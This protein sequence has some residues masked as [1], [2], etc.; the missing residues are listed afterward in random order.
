MIEN[1]NDSFSNPA[2]RGPLTGHAAGAGGRN[3]RL[4]RKVHLEMQSGSQG[5]SN[6]RQAMLFVAGGL[7]AGIAV[8]SWLGR[9]ALPGLDSGVDRSEI[10]A[11]TSMS[12]DRAIIE[13]LAA[14]ERRVADETERRV[15]LESTL[16]TL[17]ERL[18]PDGV[19]P[20]ADDAAAPL[21]LNEIDRPNRAQSFAALRAQMRQQAS[22]DY[23]REQLIAAGF[24]PDQAQSLIDRESQMR[25]EIMN[26]SYEARRQGEA[27]NPRDVQ[28]AMQTE[29][30]TGLGDDG[31]ARYLE[32]TGQPTSVGVAEV[33]ENSAGQLAGIQP[34]D[35][36]VGYD[37]ERVFNLLDLQALT[38]A[39]EPGDTIAVDILRD[40]QPMQLYISRGPLGITGGGF[41][42]PRGTVF[43]AATPVFVP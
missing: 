42:G 41:R 5:P 16:A 13:R 25:L 27:F 1:Y 34:G 15:A 20:L 8:A 19:A 9:S 38:F 35:E 10:F 39:G 37:G 28:Q 2:T 23:R 11:E 22:P 33:L 36:I 18:G 40:G 43:G 30:R 6:M 7:I 12:S 17:T 31:Y 4:D 14:L 21:D 3:S 32:A 29:L 26:A 24:T